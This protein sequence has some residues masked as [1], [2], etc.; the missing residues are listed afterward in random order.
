[1]FSGRYPCSKRGQKVYR[2]AM[3]VSLTDQELSNTF[4]VVDTSSELIL[5]ALIVDADLLYHQ[6]KDH[7]LKWRYSHTTPSSFQYI[8]NSSP[9]HAEASS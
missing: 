7:H 4:G 2:L 6:Q 3:T 1:M 9:H 8:E 5:L